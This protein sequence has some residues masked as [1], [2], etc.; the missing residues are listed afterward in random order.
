MILVLQDGARRQ[1]DHVQ[2]PRQQ[3]EVGSRQAGEDAVCVDAAGPFAR[4]GLLTSQVDVRHQ[5]IP[6]A[7][8]A[9]PRGGANL[10]QDAYRANLF[11][12][13]VPGAVQAVKARR[14]TIS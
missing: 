6:M 4:R 5:P 2:V 10:P 1:R 12:E 11:P 14:I 9:L 7:F 13:K 3:G 8:A